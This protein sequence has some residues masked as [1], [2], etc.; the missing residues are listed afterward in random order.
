MADLYYV[1]EGYVD[2]GYYTY[3][4]EAQ[5]SQAAAATM[6]VTCGILKET[7]VT[8]SPVFSPTLTVS[9]LKNAFAVLDS[10]TSFTTTANL[11]TD[12]T[13]LLEFFADL[14]AM[15]DR[16]RDIT[17]TLASSATVT[18]DFGATE[19]AQA[20]LS[21]AFT[22]SVSAVLTLEGSA[23]LSSAA[24][25]TVEV[26]AVYDV[27]SNQV[28]GARLEYFPERFLGTT[29]LF[30]AVA[31]SMIVGEFVPQEAAAD[32]TATTTLAINL[33][34]IVEDSS[35]QAAAFTQTI[36]EERIRDANIIM[37]F[38]FSPTMVVGEQQAGVFNLTAS[39][40]LTTNTRRSRSTSL[41]SSSISTGTFNAIQYKAKTEPLY[42]R[43][44]TLKA[45]TSPFAD[46]GV[47]TDQVF[48]GTY[49]GF[50]T[51]PTTT[52]RTVGYDS[53]KFLPNISANEDFFLR[54]SIRSSEVTLGRGVFFSIGNTAPSS[55][56]QSTGIQVGISSNGLIGISV[57]GFSMSESVGVAQFDPNRWMTIRIR[58]ESGILYVRWDKTG[59]NG[60]EETWD[61]PQLKTEID[62]SNYAYFRS[63]S[64]STA[65]VY[66]DDFV[67]LKGTSISTNENIRNP[68]YCVFN[69][70]FETGTA[71]ESLVLDQY[72]TAALSSTF[73]ET[74]SGRYAPGT[75][76][77]NF[78]AKATQTATTSV[79]KETSSTQSSTATMSITGGRLQT[80][81]VT[82]DSTAQQTA[83]NTV[84]RTTSVSMLGFLT[85][86]AANTRVLK[87]EFNFLV[88]TALAA[89]TIATYEGSSSQSVS[90]TAQIV[91]E[92]T[93]DT[94]SAQTAISDIVIST[95]DSLNKLASASLSATSTLTTDINVVTNTTVTM[96]VIAAELAATMRL[97][98]LLVDDNTQVNMTVTGVIK[99]GT[100]VDFH[101]FAA[102]TVATGKI[103]ESGSSMS[104]AFGKDFT[105]IAG[106]IASAALD[107]SST[108]QIQPQA[109]YDGIL[110]VN[111]FANSNFSVKITR[112]G[113]YD[114]YAES[115]M[116]VAGDRI[117]GTTLQANVTTLL[118]VNAGEIEQGSMTASVAAAM[119]V[120]GSILHIDDIVYIIP[121]EYR[122]FYIGAERRTFSI[123][124]EQRQYLIGE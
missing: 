37:P 23:A 7:S 89:T 67:F 75:L 118:A 20:D 51:S 101:V 57:N 90:T 95:F 34:K 2:T 18:V 124:R 86:M 73:T 85:Q 103:V 32:L 27:G 72:A 107:V 81:A 105:A 94:G 31:S 4:A 65:N 111:A 59:F 55:G 97:A 54:F 53:T 78:S 24:A 64:S 60:Y 11:T 39:S 3:Q 68:N 71:K 104:A 22:Q 123:A 29:F 61:L 83:D 66:I 35:T 62:T 13:G 48:S 46:I 21:A 41:A 63:P 84:T 113:D 49:S 58:R 80:T 38:A 100:V 1:E 15:A 26:D 33:E 43:P 87:G 17:A 114:L 70:D 122:E 96:P 16:T 116:S 121:R 6:A 88:D 102:Q 30:D 112:L 115:T 117:R 109:I 82:L 76:R 108:A 56:Y 93:R 42:N 79:T 36:T 69:F 28:V 99:S 98:G 45:S 77:A 12:I 8:I 92:A 9:I 119:T 110:A 47:S 10:T 120:G 25:Q 5:S 74:A 52:Y 50:F 44:Y 14:D 19:N 91:A 106:K 40:S